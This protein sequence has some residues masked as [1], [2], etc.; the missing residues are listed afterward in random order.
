[1]FH[2]LYARGP[3]LSS[4]FWN[5]PFQRWLAGRLGSLS[6]ACSTN[7]AGHAEFLAR[8]APQQRGRIAV[9]PVFSTVGEPEQSPRLRG[10]PPYL[11]IFGGGKWQDEAFTTH[12]KVLK[13]ACELLEIE[14]IITI[15]PPSTAKADFDLPVEARGLLPAAEVS[16]CL[17]LVRVGLVN[18][19]SGYLGKSS[20]FAAYCAHG[21]M[22]L[23]GTPNASELDGLRGGQHY[24][25]ASRLTQPVSPETMQEIADQATHWYSGHSIATTAARVAVALRDGS[26]SPP[27]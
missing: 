13:L 10:R 15:G 27:C 19:F 26:F 4:S 24:M 8:R 5:S 6:D 23:S 11:A 14:K 20:I 25:V 21:V 9:S 2:E 16:R 7:M 1:M 17:S 18:Y 3:V 22:P 12:R